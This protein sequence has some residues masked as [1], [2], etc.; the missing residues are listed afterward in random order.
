MYSALKMK[1]ADCS[2]AWHN[3]NTYNHETF[4]SQWWKFLVCPLKLNDSTGWGVNILVTVF[5]LTLSQSDIQ[6]LWG[7]SGQ[8]CKIFKTNLVVF[9]VKNFLDSQEMTMPLGFHFSMMA[10]K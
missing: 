7:A 9:P 2:E 5:L 6:A 8:T 4:K 1:A 10:G 3:I